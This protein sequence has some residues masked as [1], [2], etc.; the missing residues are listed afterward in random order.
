MRFFSISIFRHLVCLAIFLCVGELYA[1]SNSANVRRGWQYKVAAG[2]RMIYDCGGRQWM[3]YTPKGPTFMYS[4]TERTKE[5]VELKDVRSG[6]SFRLFEDHCDKRKSNDGNWKRMTE[7][8]WVIAP[9]PRQFDRFGPLDYCLRL[10]YFVPKDRSPKTDYATRIRVVME[11]VSEFFRRDLVSKRHRTEGLQFE[12]DENGLPVVH[13]VSGELTASDYNDNGAFQSV[14]HHQRIASEINRQMRGDPARRVVVVFAETYGDGP[15]DLVWPGHIAQAFPLSPDG[16]N[17]TFSA[18]MLQDEFCALN[19]DDQKKLFFDDTPI[20]GRRA[21]GHSG[22][23]SPTFEFVEDA[24]GGVIH[25][26]G[27]ALG[28]PHDHRNA[29]IYIMGQGFRNLRW[30][31]APSRFRG[32][33]VGFSRDNARL[34]MSSRYLSTEVDRLD[35]QPPT[36][37]FELKGTS[38]GVEAILQASDDQQLKMVVLI[39]EA[40]RHRS[41]VYARA[42][43]GTSDGFQTRLPASVLNNSNEVRIRA[44]VVDSGGN[45]TRLSRGISSKP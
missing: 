11:V 39:D 38:R 40:S 8:N 15:A 42:L 31:L 33:R 3:G 9:D 43:K 12:R 37:K 27:H 18:W 28:L 41:T 32:R 16:G 6:D 35:Y 13:L 7:G 34:L 29:E 1:Q 24:F 19:V 20:R 2:A 14:R 22:P 30:N 36:V 21:I 17:A 4:E 45:Y 5:F 44:F 23:S 25:E 26:V 10:V